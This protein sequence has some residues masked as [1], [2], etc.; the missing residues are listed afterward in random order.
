M[1]DD[2]EP[3]PPDDEPAPVE[4]P[5]DAALEPLAD[6]EPSTEEEPAAVDDDS[7]AADDEP[8]ALLAGW[9]VAELPEEPD[10]REVLPAMD[11]GPE[12]ETLPELD[13]ELLEELLD[14][15]PVPPELDEPLSHA[16]KPPAN[17][18]TTDAP[19]L[20]TRP[21]QDIRNAPNMTRRHIYHKQDRGQASAHGG[22]VGVPP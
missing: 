8:P 9:E 20:L 21:P 17:N 15:L 14:E 5:L 11:D 10:A 3:P 12:V 18:S 2:E 13:D 4:E 19:H 16:N 1:P 7:V 6:E 22:V